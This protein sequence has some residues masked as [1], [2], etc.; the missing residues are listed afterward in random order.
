[1]KRGTGGVVE[2]L[3]G[4]RERSGL[5]VK[6][7]A[8]R[9][10]RGWLIDDLS[11]RHVT[12]G[13]FS[14]VGVRCVTDIEHLR[15]FES[16]MIDQ[17]EIGV[18]GFVVRRR[19]G[20]WEWLLQGKTEPGTVCGTQVGPSVQATASNY[21]CVHG[22]LATPMIECFLT[23]MPNVRTLVDV[24]QSEQG[25]CFLGK[26]NRNAILEVADQFSD[27]DMP[28]WAWFSTNEVREALLADFAVNTD[29]RSVLCCADWG[30]CADAGAA[31]ARWR[32]QGGFGEALL[33]SF[34]RSHE[35]GDIV[36]TLNR[37]RATT[38]MRVVRS[39]LY[40]L[41][42]WRV[43]SRGVVPSASNA[44]RSVQMFSVST[45]DREVLNWCQPLVVS[46]GESRIALLCTM[47]SGVLR[48]LLR[49]SVEPGFVERVQFGPTFISDPL[50]SQIEWVARALADPDSL[51][52]ASVLQSDEG[53][54]FAYSVARYEIV[55]VATTWGQEPID[56]GIWV[57]LA[58]LKGMTAHPGL[59][60]NEARSAV[61]LLL[62]WA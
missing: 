34:E 11:L 8:L 14:V 44:L 55:E 56:D 47:V 53:G 21:Q 50:H 57:T 48:F 16:P 52:R 12:G 2:W 35:I 37:R 45:S 3:D 6:R 19:S 10:C 61:S 26:Y 58:E 62:A 1:M 28:N 31:F 41:R 46:F 27:P 13:F 15:N 20:T 7:I 23:R 18:L 30:L 33:G 9:E 5:S 29:A 54:R 36:A 32:K 43:D 17:P 49:L 60:T 40:A 59:L 25:D 39:S 4:L 38:E 51:V 42:G 24:I 22:G